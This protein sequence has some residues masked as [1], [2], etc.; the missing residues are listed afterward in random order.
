VGGVADGPARVME[1]PLCVSKSARKSRERY[2]WSENIH[3]DRLKP[4]QE[5]GKVAS[6]TPRDPQPKQHNK[7]QKPSKITIRSKE[8]SSPRLTK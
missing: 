4:N 7:K 3:P 5:T 1:K 8:H 6:A 2:A